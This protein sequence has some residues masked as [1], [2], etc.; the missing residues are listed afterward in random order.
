MNPGRN[1]S[2]H[3]GSGRK[4][5]KCCLLRENEF[6]AAR[7]ALFIK[8]FMEDELLGQQRILESNAQNE[9]NSFLTFRP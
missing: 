1:D 3:C 6:R 8:E 7:R 2:C 5:K 9:I 4:Y